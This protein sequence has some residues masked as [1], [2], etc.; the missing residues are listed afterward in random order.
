MRSNVGS[1]LVMEKWVITLSTSSYFSTDGDL[2]ILS[3][4]VLDFVKC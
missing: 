3:T 4:C 1:V 2:L